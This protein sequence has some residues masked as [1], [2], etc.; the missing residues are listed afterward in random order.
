[1]IV[2][3]TLYLKNGARVANPTFN[4]GIVHALLVMGFVDCL[5]CDVR[6]NAK[7]TYIF[8]YSL[9]CGNVEV[10]TVLQKHCLRYTT[11]CVSMLEVFDFYEKRVSL[12]MKYICVE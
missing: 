11:C 9:S 7:P 5:L 12:W 3:Q 4:K 2:Y 1:M 8:L 10:M 6:N